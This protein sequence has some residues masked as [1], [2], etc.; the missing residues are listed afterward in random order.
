MRDENLDAG[1]VQLVGQLSGAVG[2]VDGGHGGS[3]LQNAE[4]GG[5]ELSAVGDKEADSV[6]LFHAETREGGGE[7]VALVVEL[8][9]GE[10]AVTVDDG[11]FVGEAG[12]GALK[13][14]EERVSLVGG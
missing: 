6:P 5:D 10:G 7:P 2:G 8:C 9:E 14:L 4:I 13:D 1:V 12:G 3:S 11:N